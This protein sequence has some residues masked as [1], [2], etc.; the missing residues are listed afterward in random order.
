M[1]VLTVSTQS[2]LD[3]EI[4]NY[5]MKGFVVAHKTEFA[6]TL[7]RT[8]KI[9]WFIAFI[10]FMFFFIGLAVYLAYYNSKKDEVITI[11]F[12]KKLQVA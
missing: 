2:D 4:N 11:N 10:G 8:K 9:D 6:V 3:M 12:E 7:T 1:K 5:I